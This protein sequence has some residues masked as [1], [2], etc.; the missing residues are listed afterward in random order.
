MDLLLIVM[1]LKALRVHHS[2]TVR[3]ILLLVDSVRRHLLL[4]L[5]LKAIETILGKKAIIDWQ[6]MQPGDAEFTYADISKAQKLLNY[7][8]STPLEEG[9]KN[10]VAWY[11][12]I[13]R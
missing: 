12:E 2:C 10:F 8:P 5:S 1:K 13:S 3:L 7:R 11:N 6:P 4:G 9:L